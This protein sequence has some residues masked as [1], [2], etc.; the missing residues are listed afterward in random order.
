M[1]NQFDPDSIGQ[2]ISGFFTDLNAQFASFVPK[3]AGMFAI[4]VVGWIVARIVQAATGRILVKTKLDDASGYLGVNNI[5]VDAGITT[6][7]SGI[8][9]RLLYWVVFLTFM[10][11][12]AEALGLASVATATNRLIAYLPNVIAACLIFLLG[13][14]FSRFVGKMVSSA[15]MASDM[16]YA[17]GL[18][19]GCQGAMVVITSVIAIEQ[20][21]IKASLLQWSLVAVLTAALLAVSISFA[22]GSREVV[23]SILAGYYLRKSLREGASIQVAGRSGTLVR[24][25][26][27]DA[28]F[29]AKDTSWSVPNQKLLREVIDREVSQ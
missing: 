4:L 8:I 23:G 6:P 11:P 14:L 13:L 16:P 20:L 18:G 22:I 7:P 2:V 26:P 10:L 12:A 19:K 25:G 29:Q 21:G 17:L 3:L 27:V 28:L 24:I 1:T 9:S 15:A 5:L